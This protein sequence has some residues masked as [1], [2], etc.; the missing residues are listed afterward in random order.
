MT[1][2]W[3][4]DNE[5]E[6]HATIS[7]NNIVLNKQCESLFEDYEY[8]MLGYSDTGKIIHIK[9]VLEGIEIEADLYRLNF[10]R[11]Y[12]RVSCT[13]F[14]KLISNKMFV[15]FSNNKKF[16]ANWNDNEKTLTI[17]LGK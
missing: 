8:C 4:K 13:N 15:D 2:K 7:N 10:N 17:D 11:S 3:F 9:P 6:L 16:R 12:I 14:I 5:S 1:I